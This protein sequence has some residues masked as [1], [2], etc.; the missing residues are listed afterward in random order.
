[1]GSSIKAP[2]RYAVIGLGHI[3]QVAIL[4]AFEQAD[5]A[6][7]TALI[8]GDD[9]KLA[10]LGERYHVGATHQFHYDEFD[11]FLKA[12]L[13]D[14]IYIALPNHLHHEY[15]V[16]A[17]RAGLHVLCEKPLGV[18]AKECR[19]M[20]DACEDN[21]VL[22]MTAYRL[23]F[24]AANMTAVTAAKGGEFGDLRFFQASFSQN[25]SPPNVRLMPLNQGGGTVYDLGIYCINA[26]R[27]LF[28]DEPYRVIA[29]SVSPDG[30]D[31]FKESD[32][33]TAAIL[34]FP[35]DRI[36]SFVSSFGASPSSTYRLVGTRGI[37]ELDPAF[38]YATNLGYEFHNKDGEF[39]AE[40]FEKRDQFGP[41]LIYFSDC[42]L[43]E[44]RPEPDGYE[45]LAD[46]MII[47]AI[48]ESA[49]TN[50]PVDLDI[51]TPPVRPDA[52]QIRTLPGFPK[53]DEIG[54]SRFSD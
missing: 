27:Y 37:A 6:E 52:A 35:N 23:H 8:S 36:A 44:R 50:Q 19:E 21:D 1:M 33:M 17:A 47:E 29:Q 30:E 31:R 48:Y 38:G 20:I 22:L 49:R 42:I 13:A 45:G 5:N 15:A 40:I 53:P 46:V 14:A 11:E 16:R 25:I 28:A 9:V 18:T 43:Q 2:V 41:E 10:I 24:E 54:A 32:E 4:P 34:L 51:P 39:H 7:L 12:G 3:A 26:A